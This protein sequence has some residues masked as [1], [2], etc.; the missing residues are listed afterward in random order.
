MTFDPARTAADVGYANPPIYD[1][2]GPAI[3]ILTRPDT[4]TSAP[5]LVRG[6]IA[7]GGFVPMHSHQDPETF[8]ILR[9][10]IEGLTWQASDQPL[11]VPVAEGGVFHVP[12]HARHAL[13][14]REAAP[15]TVLIVSTLAMVRFSSRPGPRS[16]H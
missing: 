15:A 9:G 10:A 14:N 5:G 3:E 16:R 2:L 8:V 13:R 4:D 11:W 7:P 12:P 1:H 6:H